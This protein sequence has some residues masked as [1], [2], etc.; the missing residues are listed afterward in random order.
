MV[1]A[2]IS[3]LQK[4]LALGQFI[5]HVVPCKITSTAAVKQSFSDSYS[6]ARDKERE[7]VRL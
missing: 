4:V 7:R 6:E 5:K 3:F 1:A 2:T